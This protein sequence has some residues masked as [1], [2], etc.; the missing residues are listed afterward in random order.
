MQSYLV[1]WGLFR[2]NFRLSGTLLFCVC[3]LSPYISRWFRGGFCLDRDC[4]A[5]LLASRSIMYDCNYSFYH[6]L[7]VINQFDFHFSFPFPQ[8]ACHCPICCY[9]LT[10]SSESL[11]GTGGA[12]LNK[13]GTKYPLRLSSNSAVLRPTQEI[14]PCGCSDQKTYLCATTP[15]C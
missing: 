9:R 2:R 8:P 11:R 15:Y 10:T 14:T 13:V 12:T 7:I 5:A 4:P 1:K 3:I 6:F